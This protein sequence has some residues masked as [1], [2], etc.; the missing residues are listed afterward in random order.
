MKKLLHLYNLGHDPFP[1]IGKGGLGY[2]LPQ[3]RL[4]GGKLG[5]VYDPLTNRHELVDVIEGD[6]EDSIARHKIIEDLMQQEEAKNPTKGDDSYIRD[7]EGKIMAKIIDVDEEEIKNKEEDQDTKHLRSQLNQLPKAGTNSIPGL[8]ELTQNL[9]L[10]NYSKFNKGEYI[11]ALLKEPPSIRYKIEENLKTNEKLIRQ[12]KVN[13]DIQKKKILEDTEY[14]DEKEDTIDDLTKKENESKQN[15]LNEMLNELYKDPSIYLI[16]LFKP[17]DDDV[18]KITAKEMTDFLISKGWTKL[19]KKKED[20]YN[21]VLKNKEMDIYYNLGI[22][23]PDEVKEEEDIEGFKPGSLVLLDPKTIEEIKSEK[24]VDDEN[25]NTLNAQLIN[26]FDT[27]RKNPNMY[28]ELFDDKDIKELSKEDYTTK[29]VYDLLYESGKQSRFPSG[30]DF[31]DKVL[32]N[33]ELVKQILISTYGIGNVDLSS[34]KINYE[35]EGTTG[36]LFTVFDAHAVNFK[37]N[38]QDK[39][40]F[41]EFKKYSNYSKNISEGKTMIEN[42][43][44]E[45]NN[46]MAETSKDIININKRI[47][48][49]K[50]KIETSDDRKEQGKL[51]IELKNNEKKLDI[52]LNEYNPQNKKILQMKFYEFMN[53]VGI[54]VKYTKFPKLPPDIKRSESSVNSQKAYNYI[55]AYENNPNR[56]K[57][58]NI[59]THD[60][61][62]E[63]NIDILICTGLKNSMVVCNLS[64]LMK[65]KDSPYIEFLKLKKTLY[66]TKQKGKKMIDYDHY[67]IPISYFKNVKLNIEYT[68]ELNKIIDKKFA[69]K[70][71]KK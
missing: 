14:D 25:I 22:T 39:Q 58:K 42:E 19:P 11:N 46:F 66:A 43:K 29:Q 31:E 64:N 15:E 4:R 48:N 33:T 5:F 49:L 59:K 17:K 30:K 69:K 51:L 61:A 55:L 47:S 2:H 57:D 35:A 34:V 52:Y 62:I 45:F 8:I 16:E 7:D 71:K 70:T 54:G 63:K 12:S 23:H 44:K 27:F 50:L 65:E 9:G 21:L 24:L 37:L 10:K 3:Y 13:I 20:L 36:D 56:R 32:A 6:D 60:L 67:N 53:P 41:I 40:A 1:H 28:E 68:K 38:G 26:T 18:S